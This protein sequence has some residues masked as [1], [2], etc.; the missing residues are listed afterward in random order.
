V[1]FVLVLVGIGVVVLMLRRDRHQLD[2]EGVIARFSTLKLTATDLYDESG[3]T[4]QRY[5]LAGMTV[6]VEDAEHY[7]SLFLMM[8]EGPLC[9]SCA[10]LRT[11]AATA[12]L[13][14]RSR[15]S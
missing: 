7:R 10:R 14:D 4:R 9:R 11:S 3:T 2:D 5:P 12:S 15:N 6:R 1:L 8:I 13:P